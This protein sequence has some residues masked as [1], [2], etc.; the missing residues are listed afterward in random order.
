MVSSL[1]PGDAGSLRKAGDIREHLRHTDSS[2]L[3]IAGVLLVFRE[4]ADSPQKPVCGGVNTAQ[5]LAS[6]PPAAL[7]T[8]DCFS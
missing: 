3:G 4:S 8:C 6:F 7:H 5:A 2:V 1:V